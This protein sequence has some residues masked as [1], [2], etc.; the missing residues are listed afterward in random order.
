MMTLLRKRFLLAA[1]TVLLGIALGGGYGAGGAFAAA[2]AMPAGGPSWLNENFSGGNSAAPIPP[3]SDS[4]VQPSDDSAA[5]PN[6]PS[7]ASS[8]EASEVAPAEPAAPPAPVAPPPAA[9]APEAPPSGQPAQDTTEGHPASGAVSPTPIAALP[10]TLERL[11]RSVDRI[12]SETLMDRFRQVVIEGLVVEVDT[13]TA[14]QWGVE[15]FYTRNESGEPSNSKLAGIGM[16]EPN[17]F[18]TGA[19]PNLNIPA[20]AS[21]GFPTI[22][23]TNSAVGIGGTFDG[24]KLVSGLIQTRIRAAVGKGKADILSQP[25]AVAV[26]GTKVTL[27][28]VDEIPF[29]DIQTGEKHV[30]TLDLSN[31]KVGIT[32]DVVPT[33]DINR[34]RVLLD[35]QRL[36]VGQ[37]NGYQTIRGV[38]RPIIQTSEVNT[39]VELADRESLL[40]SG[41]KAIRERG[42]RKGVPLLKDI[43]VLGYLFGSAT[44]VQERVDILFMVTPHV[45]D[46]GRNPLFPREF[47]NR[48]LQ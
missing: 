44:T 4:A 47:K 21:T 40:I 8:P 28:T 5:Q 16:T 7:D 25:I 29:Q 10:T 31:K 46:P 24:I 41:I 22:G 19:T 9:A 6:A 27:S 48:S 35:I 18:A 14:R 15:W 42:A 32:L 39:K 37:L 2:T 1:L 13:S 26:N 20:N 12:S 11:L 30:A 3:S 38:A 43:P 34:E 45:L 36:S 33:F 23:S 17:T